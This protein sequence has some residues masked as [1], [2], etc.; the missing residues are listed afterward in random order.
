[1]ILVDSDVFL[2]DLRY[3]R[4]QRFGDNR[5]FLDR[6]AISNTGCSSESGSS[7]A[8]GASGVLRSPGA[9]SP[10]GSKWPG[11]VYAH[12]RARHFQ[13]SAIVA[14]PG[15]LFIGDL[16][17]TRTMRIGILLDWD[18]RLVSLADALVVCTATARMTNHPDNT[19]PSQG[20]P[21]NARRTMNAGGRD[22]E[23]TTTSPG[24]NEIPYAKHL[25]RQ[26][27]IRLGPGHARSISRHWQPTAASPTRR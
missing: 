11:P 2:I 19:Q 17:I 22:R 3:R 15:T 6:L 26:V 24:R 10:T 23:T 5:A 25:K 7:A 14:E 4:D 27:T 18:E 8:A 9:Q 1:M 21:W 20:Q 16:R 12:G 13:D